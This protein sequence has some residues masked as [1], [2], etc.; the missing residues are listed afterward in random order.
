MICVDARTFRKHNIVQ[1]WTPRLPRHR[2]RIGLVRLKSCI[3]DIT[4]ICA[5]LPPDFSGK[6]RTLY[7]E[8]IAILGSIINALPTRTTPVLLIDANAHMGMQ[9]NGGELANTI[10][11]SHGHVEP[12]VEN[13]AGTAFRKLL[14]TTGLF[15]VNT[16]YKTGKTF[17]PA[18]SNG[19]PTR[20]PCRMC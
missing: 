20:P 13:A 14:Q 19:A 6:C 15:A 2:G 4:I 17:Y 3:Y 1:V 16:A 10:T 11:S 12:E 9:R 7:L 8:L 18:S 5:Y